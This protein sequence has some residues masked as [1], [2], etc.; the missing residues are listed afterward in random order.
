[1]PG[2]H[3]GEGFAKTGLQAPVGFFQADA[4]FPA[5]AY[6]VIGRPTANNPKYYW[7]ETEMHDQNIRWFFSNAPIKN[8]ALKSVPFPGY[9]QSLARSVNS[10]VTPWIITRR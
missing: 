9:F 3:L 1:M 2:C 4:D 7:P 5:Y 6:I 10:I 8:M